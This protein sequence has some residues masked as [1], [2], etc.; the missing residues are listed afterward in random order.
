MNVETRPM[1]GRGWLKALSTPAPGLF[2]AL[3]VA[4]AATFVA[5]AVGAPVMPFA[6]L[7]GIALNGASGDE[8][9]RAGLAFAS[10]PLLQVGIALLGLKIS[11]MQVASLGSDTLLLVASGTAVSIASGLAL[12][13]LF[14]LPSTL[15]LLAGGATGICGASAALAISSTLPASPNKD[16]ETAFVIVTVTTLST[17]AM[18]AYPVIAHF[19]GLDD[20]QTGIFLGATIH[21]VAQVVGAGYAVSEEAGDTATIVKLFRVALLLPT[22]LGIALTM[23]SRASTEGR[24]PWLLPPFAVAFAVLVVVNSS[25][26]V[27]TALRDVSIALSNWCL[28]TAVAAIG[29]RTSIS[30][31][32][33]MGWAALAVPIGATILLM[34]LVIS[35]EL[36][37]R[38]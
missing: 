7:I 1:A 34:T 35:F 4:A 21:D 3:T 37:M 8:Q 17:V 25:G 36:I 29:I 16:R 23:R 19:L 30:G 5:Q 9:L 12:A 24:L 31:T 28:A 22:V 18:L 32:L 6:L 14:G 2:L 26:F 15:G 38:N 33:R 13:R 11:V 20:R 10:R 27:P